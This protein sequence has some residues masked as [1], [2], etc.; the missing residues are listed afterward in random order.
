LNRGGRA[1][2]SQKGGRGW[3]DIVGRNVSCRLLKEEVPRQQVAMI[4]KREVR[5][6]WPVRGEDIDGGRHK[7]KKKQDGSASMLV[8]ICQ[9]K[10]VY[11]KGVKVNLSYFGRVGK[12]TAGIV[13]SEEETRKTLVETGE[14]ER[15][16]SER[17]ARK[18]DTT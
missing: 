1:C 15:R 17:K 14:G 11:G 3:D 2:I 18:E 10:D 9:K 4:G 5:C 7:R 6:S 13:R 12:I 8:S 16:V